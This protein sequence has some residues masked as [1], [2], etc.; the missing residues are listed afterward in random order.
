[1]CHFFSLE[2]SVLIVIWMTFP[3]IRFPLGFLSRACRSLRSGPLRRLS[4]PSPSCVWLINPWSV[5]L[6]SLLFTGKL[7]GR[8]PAVSQLL[9]RFTRSLNHT[10]K[11]SV[12][13]CVELIWIQFCLQVNGV[14][15]QMSLRV[16]NNK[17]DLAIFALALSTHLPVKRDLLC[18]YLK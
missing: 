11:Y 17:L 5:W 16:T 7:K 2:S 12:Y 13:I 18:M 6:I 8:D 1:M 4:C 3:L 9:W 14:V 15:A 10:K